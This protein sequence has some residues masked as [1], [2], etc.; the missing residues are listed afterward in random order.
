MQVKGFLAAAVPAGVRYAGR[1]DLGLIFSQ[2]PAVTAGAFTTNKV[3]AAP[4]QLDMERLR[5]GLAQAILVNSGNANACTGKEG[6]DQA[7]ATG[8]LAARE[9]GIDPSLVQVASTGVIGQPLRLEP[10]A[11]AM[12]G[13]VASLSPEGFEQLAQAI[14]TTDLVPKIAS[15]TVDIGGVE[16]SILGIAKGSGMIMPD[17][18][19]M[20]C[21]VVTDAQIVFPVLNR[22]VKAGV[23]HTFNRITVDGDTSTN[24]TVLVMA[25]G[26]AGNPWIDED[27]LQAAALFGDALK[28]VFKELA[29]KIVADG[30]G[31]TKLVTVRIVG[32]RDEDEALNAA[33]TIA[34][35]ALVK[36]A[37]FGEDAN[38]GRIIAALG[39]SE[40]TFD[41]Q[42]VGISFDD[43]SLV[44]NGV[45]LGADREA[46]A[47]AVL[48]QPRFTVTV[49]LGEGLAEAE[50][51]TCDFSYD[52][53]KINA[54]Y[55]S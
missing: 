2:T 20:L 41:P 54:D 13:L 37:F 29:L 6:M 17:M 45:A 3:K 1:L 49:H 21:F 53:V 47:T 19:T 26:A 7:L 33:Q 32:A 14:M 43:I 15:A 35:S 18:A 23:G 16:V 34:N 28:G 4:V 48:K 52:Y 50:V 5:S 24:D 11:Q 40:C 10:F 38:W 46:A 31:A 30:E 12:P 27:N 44:E 8:A 36:T 22:L 42:R 39:R 51:Y 25:N 55:R 9:L